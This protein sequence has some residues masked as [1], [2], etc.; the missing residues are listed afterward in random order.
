MDSLYLW[1]ER[2]KY[3]DGPA[4]SIGNTSSIGPTGPSNG[5]ETVR[6]M[7]KLYDDLWKKLSLHLDEYFRLCLIIFDYDF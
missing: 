3:T 4:G 5:N 1:N 6:N 2:A 7:N